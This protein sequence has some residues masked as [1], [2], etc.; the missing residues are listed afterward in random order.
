MD[1]IQVPYQLFYSDPKVEEYVQNGKR[2]LNEEPVTHHL[3]I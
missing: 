1:A 2:V 3:R